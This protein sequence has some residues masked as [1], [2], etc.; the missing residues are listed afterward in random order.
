M[1]LPVQLPAQR[2][3]TLLKMGKTKAASA[4]DKHAHIAPQHR[5]NMQVC[6]A[7]AC[8]RQQRE[9]KQWARQ[10]EHDAKN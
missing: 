8:A 3:R 9:G 6:S 10:K 1:K 5:L 4:T 7:V 2:A